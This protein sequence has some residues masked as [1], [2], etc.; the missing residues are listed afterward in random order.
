M[1]SSEYS[2]I[3]WVGVTNQ[4]ETPINIKE[5]KE[6]CG[7]TFITLKWDRASDGDLPILGY[8]VEMTTA[9]S[10]LYEVIY[11]GETDSDQL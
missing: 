3:L 4:A 2:E 10:T 9:E 5:I 7:A 8:R 1:G 11:N 6:S